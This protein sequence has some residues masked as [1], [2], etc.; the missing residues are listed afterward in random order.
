[1][2]IS[3]NETYFTAPLFGDFIDS[4]FIAPFAYGLYHN[5]IKFFVVLFVKIEAVFQMKK[6]SFHIHIIFYSSP[7]LLEVIFSRYICLC[8]RIVL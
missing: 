4:L 8:R 6:S 2:K 3:A 1:M 7:F 5:R